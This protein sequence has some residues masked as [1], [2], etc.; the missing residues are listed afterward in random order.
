V[1]DYT[2]GALAMRCCRSSSV[3]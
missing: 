2:P 1:P 3:L